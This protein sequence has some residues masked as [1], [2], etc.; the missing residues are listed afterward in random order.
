MSTHRKAYLEIT[1]RC[2]LSCAFCPGTERRAHVMTED[3]FIFLAKR[4]T[5]WA[6]YLYF[7]LMGEPTAHPLLPNFIKISTELGLKPI[8]TTNG[9][10]LS[11]RG[12]EIITA[13]PYKINISLHAFEANPPKM[14]FEE[15]IYGC[16]DFA[17]RASNEGIITVLRLWNLDGKAD[18]ALHEKNDMIL[19]AM[20]EKFSS[21]WKK[22]RSGE[23]LK[24]RVF[25]EWGEKFDWPEIKGS[26]LNENGFC[27]GLR[28]Q[29]G[30]LCDGSVVPCC[31]DRNGDITL[32]NLFDSSL[33]EILLSKR[34]CELYDGF[35][36]H[37]CS[38]ELCKRCMRASYYRRAEKTK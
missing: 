14:T 24:D 21:E 25:L 20:R 31:L 30:V 9:T 34:A 38:E 28:D 22:T 29:V 32:G 11:F 35:T 33:E 36:S 3:E 16:L 27:Y 2:N 6:E 8:I 17:E 18:G 7:H 26:I 19:S 37:I 4:L 23:K 13:K 1:N 15:Y 12:D 5:P 10:L